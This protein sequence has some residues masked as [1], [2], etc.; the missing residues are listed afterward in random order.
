MHYTRLDTTALSALWE[1]A[2]ADGLGVKP[3]PRPRSSPAIGSRM[4]MPE[5]ALARAFA[6][7]GA[8]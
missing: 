7:E 6:A 2:L 5:P 1:E 8:A 4:R 3:P